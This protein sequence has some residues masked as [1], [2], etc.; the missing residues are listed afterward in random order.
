MQIFNLKVQMEQSYIVNPMPRYI[1]HGSPDTYVNLTIGLHNGLQYVY[2]KVGTYTGKQLT[3]LGT[4]SAT[5]INER[6]ESVNLKALSTLGSQIPQWKMQAV[7]IVYISICMRGSLQCGLGLGAF[8]GPLVAEATWSC[9]YKC[10]NHCD[11][12]LSH[13]RYFWMPPWDETNRE[14]STNSTNADC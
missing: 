2:S 10:Y 1:L 7:G 13:R 3:A 14:V 4:K 6:H 11:Y 8:L 5:G 12:I 9:S